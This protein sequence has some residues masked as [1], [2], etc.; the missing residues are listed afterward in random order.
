MSGTHR[1]G[2]NCVFVVSIV[3]STKEIFYKFPLQFSHSEEIFKIQKNIIRIIMNLCR[4][5]S[6]RHL[7]KELNILPTQSQYIFSIFLF[8]IKNKDQFLLN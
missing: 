4:N 5:A 1:G 3:S 6:C 7:F 2:Y 8:V